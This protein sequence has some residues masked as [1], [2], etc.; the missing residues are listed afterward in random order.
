[1]AEHMKHSEK[2]I[3]HTQSG[4]V[5]YEAKFGRVQ[6]EKDFVMEVDMTFRSSMQDEDVRALLSAVE[7]ILK[8]TRSYRGKK[9]A[10]DGKTWVYRDT[11]RRP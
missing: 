7:D 5:Q 9:I 11:K 8:F 6:D 2:K 1:M 4:V 10:H 3:L